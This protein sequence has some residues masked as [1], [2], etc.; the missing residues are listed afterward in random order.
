MKL[1][2]VL[3][4]HH[5][6]LPRR[7]PA[8]PFPL[9]LS[10][11]VKGQNLPPRLLQSRPSSSTGSDNVDFQKN[12]RRLI[13]VQKAFER[14]Q[15]RGGFTIR[16]VVQRART[17]PAEERRVLMNQYFNANNE[18]WIITSGMVLKEVARLDAS[19]STKMQRL[20]G[21]GKVTKV[22][23]LIL[24]RAAEPRHGITPNDLKLL[25]KAVLHVASRGQRWY[26]RMNV[27]GFTLGACLI[28]YVY[29]T[30]NWSP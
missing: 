18:R 10:T 14:A 7:I 8:D 1:P 28:Y 3:L 13:A 29:T 19:D 5:H 27:V 25:Q 4:H 21:R 2:N 20:K 23:R 17:V 15:S 16:E 30:M 9:S 12:I 22:A 24:D 26:T 11:P 6:V